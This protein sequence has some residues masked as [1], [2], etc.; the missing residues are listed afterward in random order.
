MFLSSMSY[1]IIPNYKFKKIVMLKNCW[2]E[3]KSKIKQ[4]HILGG[5]ENE[6]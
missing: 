5:L 1:I 6:K 3:K 4:S 2:R